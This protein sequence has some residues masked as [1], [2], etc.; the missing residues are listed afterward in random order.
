M[1]TFT[2]CNLL[3]TAFAAITLLFTAHQ[4]SAT[5]LTYTAPTPDPF[6]IAS[7][8]GTVDVFETITNP[9]TF[10]VDIT[11]ISV[12]VT[13]HN[14][15]GAGDP[16]DPFDIVDSAND[17]G[18]TCGAITGGVTIGAGGLCTVELALTVSGVAPYHAAGHPAYDD[19]YGDNKID[20]TVDSERPG[21]AGTT[22][23]VNAKFIAQV[24]YVYTPEP[25][26]LL[27]LG[28]G[29]LGLA[30]LA[31]WKFRRN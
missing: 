4:A 8:A 7:N 2:T 25:S 13:T 10:A 29:M 28:S 23:S 22:P 11:S 31:R 18:G 30:G 12:S 3:A 17:I 19:N 27:L 9:N 20:V 1:R 16:G 6:T 15:G 14:N 21:H 26:S 24:D 5:A